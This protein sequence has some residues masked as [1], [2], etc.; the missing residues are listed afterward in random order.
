MINLPASEGQIIS[1]NAVLEKEKTT[2]KTIHYEPHAPISIENNTDF[3]VQAQNEGWVGDGSREEPYIITGL[4]ILR[5]DYDPIS[6]KNTDVYFYIS[7]NLLSCAGAP[8]LVPDPRSMGAPVLVLTN[9]T[10][11]TIASNVIQDAVGPSIKIRNSANITLSNNTIRGKS[12]VSYFGEIDLLRSHNINISGNTVFT[13]RFY[14]SDNNSVLY[15][16]FGGTKKGTH[17]I[18]L[19]YSSNNLISH[20]TFHD[21]PFGPAIVLL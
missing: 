3:A 13:I 18:T 21:Y 17:G 19:E 4:Y 7:E 1:L 14:L 5:S 20:N 15:N 10:H 12:D 8:T 16:E 6:I 11:G 2:S 9:V